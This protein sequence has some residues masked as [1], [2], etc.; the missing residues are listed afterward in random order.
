MVAYKSFYLFFAGGNFYLASV[1]YFQSEKKGKWRKKLSPLLW[2][3]ATAYVEKEG[4]G[5]EEQPF[6]FGT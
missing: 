3:P 4:A 5:K 1:R 6:Y 2:Y